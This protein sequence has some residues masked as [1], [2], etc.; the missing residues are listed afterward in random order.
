MCLQVNKLPDHTASLQRDGEGTGKG[1]WYPINFILFST[2]QLWSWWVA[3]GSHSLPIGTKLSD[4]PTREE[5]S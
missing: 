2:G 1:P 3:R 4:M 5:C